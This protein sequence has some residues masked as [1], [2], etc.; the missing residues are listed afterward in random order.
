MSFWVRIEIAPEGRFLIDQAA[1]LPNFA[2]R[3]ARV[4][5]G[6]PPIFLGDRGC[7]IGYLF[8][9]ASPCGRILD[10][11]AQAVEEVLATRGASLLADYWGGYVAVIENDDG[12]TDVLRD[13]S[14]LLP[15]YVRRNGA[16]THLASDTTAL[17]PPGSAR[18][19]FETI[20][21]TFASMDALGR[22]TGLA[23][24]QELL[25]GERLHTA[26]VGL[27]TT[28]L[29]SPWDHVPRRYRRSFAEDAEALRVTV[30]E[31][32]GSWSSCFESILLGASGG[33]DSSIVAAAAMPRTPRLRL[34]TLVE[35]GT[36][37]DERRYAEAIAAKLGV[38]LAARHFE[39]S[40]VDVTKAVLPH[41][42]LP[43]ALPIFQAIEAIHEE[44]QRR[45]PIDA[46]FSGNGGDNIFCN[47]HSA[48]PL[49]DRILARGSPAGAW[50]T[51]RDLAD[52]TGS[53][54]AEVFRHSWRR[55]CDRRLPHSIRFD[56]MGLTP[57]AAAA[58]IAD[59]DRHP[60]LEPPPGVLPGQIAYVAM[61]ARGQK[62]VELYPRHKKAPQI[63][64]LLSQ[65]IAELCLSIPTWHAVRDGRDR[66]VA[67]AAFAA[68]LPPLVAH[69]RTKGSP[70]GFLRRIFEAQL[71]QAL[72]FLQGGRLVEAGIIDPLFIKRVGDGAW[73][74]DG[75]DHRI[76]T[77]CAAEAWVRWWE[78]GD[79]PRGN[80]GRS[81]A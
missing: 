23:G 73:R 74:D 37:G 66:A 41:F 58:A 36:E 14:G 79:A 18:I 60:W 26:P 30:K 29:W 1:A 12:S 25:P 67:R 40:T 68:D 44:E 48:A 42:P 49:A 75:R 16:S 45:K 7:I 4:W 50:R 77:F 56:L 70:Q 35:A 9:R 6:L 39:L 38:P 17:I 31:A 22:R 55:L 24:V 69:R 62:S 59:E 8:R 21:R 5:S 53:P 20:A 43:L 57:R 3:T 19:D 47:M 72:N 80:A 64:P 2:S 65:P 27:T 10:L 34:L 63:T 13:P 52:L 51:A 76:L 33:V 61:Q 54:L 78:S 46:F 15:C 71:P 11:G 32:V 81:A 28:P